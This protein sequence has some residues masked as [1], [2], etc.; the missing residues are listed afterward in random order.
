MPPVMYSFSLDDVLP[1]AIDGVDVALVAG[2]RRDVR[3]ARI[4]VGRAHG[5][6]HGLGLV[7][8]PAL[9]LVVGDARCARRAVRAAR[10][11]A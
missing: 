2:Q 6:A 11:R 10:R 7:H 1:D 4:H 5:V 8:D 3:H 9:R